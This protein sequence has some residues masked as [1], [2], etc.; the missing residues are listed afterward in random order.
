MQ[1][2]ETIENAK[3]LEKEMMEEVMK[4]KDEHHHHH[5]DDEEEE[6]EHHHHDDDDEEDEH[7]HHHHD[8]D[9]EEEHE[10][11]HHDGEC[12]CHDH[13]HEGH[14]HADDI[15]DSWGL[16]TPAK[17]T[18]EDIEGFLKALGDDE[19]Y[20]LVLRA[21]GMVPAADGTW[22]YFDYVPDESNVR[23]GQP[24]VTGKFCVIGSKLKEDN[25]KKLFA[26]A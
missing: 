9:E 5:H 3:S 22:I 17:Y 10:H 18:K 4:L 15:F 26:K 20:G 6:H 19:T 13:H 24:D 11:H 14:H 12:C 16:E 23:T 7:E 2:L 1:I 21:K 8:D 25:L